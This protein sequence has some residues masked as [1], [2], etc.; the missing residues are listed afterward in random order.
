M[1]VKY[2]QLHYTWKHRAL[3][4]LSQRMNFTYTMRHGLAAGMRRRGGLGFIPWGT[5]Q[6]AETRLLASLDLTG[7]TVY[8]IGAF[9]GLLTMFFSRRAR[10][11]VAW[12]PNPASRAR[13]TTNLQLNAVR[14]V[15]V[16]DVGLSDRHADAALVYDPLMPGA[17]SVNTAIVRQMR[18]GA[19]AV[20]ETVIHLVR[21]DDDQCHHRLPLPDFV[22][23]DVEGMELSVIRGAE[24]LLRTC[25]P[26]VYVELHGAEDVDKRQN[27]HDVAAALWDL[28]Y[29]DIVHCATAKKLTPDTIG[30]PGRIYCPRPVQATSHN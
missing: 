9:E 30:R 4:A 10:H 7:L 25:W 26:A 14:N 8:D 20:R 2:R 13:L 23:I 6:D 11:V 17:A 1:T 12:E 15:T 28:G 29:R 27:A 19:P 22:K 21:L 5:E 3:A 24:H 16:R 18:D